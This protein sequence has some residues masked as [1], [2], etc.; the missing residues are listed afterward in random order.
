MNIGGKLS[1]CAE[2]SGI[3]VWLLFHVDLMYS[4]QKLMYR[5]LCWGR[6][7]FHLS[8][9]YPVADGLIFS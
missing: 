6:W 8:F 4:F 2:V 5:G 7:S 9:G 3:T 1:R